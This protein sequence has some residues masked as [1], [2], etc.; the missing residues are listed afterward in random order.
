MQ[1]SGTSQ[2]G[3]SIVFKHAELSIDFFKIL[4]FIDFFLEREKITYLLFHL[5]MPSLVTSC[6]CPDWGLNLLPWH[7]R[8]TCEQT[9]VPASTDSIRPN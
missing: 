8:M 7:I 4:L 1:V 2:R 3:D 6:G 9:V 5:F